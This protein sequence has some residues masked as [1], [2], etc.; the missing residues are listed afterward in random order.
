[1]GSYTTVCSTYFLYSAR[2]VLSLRT[3][4]FDFST[5]S[6][7][8]VSRIRTTPSPRTSDAERIF[9]M[10][11]AAALICCTS[12][13][14]FSTIRPF[15]VLFTM[16]S[17]KLSALSFRYGR[18]ME[19]SALP[20]KMAIAFSRQVSYPHE[21]QFNSSSGRVLPMRFRISL[22]SYSAGGT[23][24]RSIAVKL[25]SSVFSAGC[26]TGKSSSPAYLATER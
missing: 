17:E 16:Q 15:G 18:H 11:R 26:S 7:M 3:L 21:P 12:R 22:I 9:M 10:R 23:S 8:F 25:F 19:I 2:Y 13:F 4:R 1:M 20:W 6:K 24:F 14:S 5:R